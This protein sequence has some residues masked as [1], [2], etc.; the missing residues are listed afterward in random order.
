MVIKK[1]F[2]VLSLVFA[3]STAACATTAAAQPQSVGQGLMQMLPMFVIFIAVFYFLMIRPQNKKAQEKKQLM[4]SL[5]AG[6]E[7][8]TSGGIVAKIKQLS[9]GYVVLSLC[10]AEMTLQRN[11]IAAVLPNGTI[12]AIK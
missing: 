6:D 3:I 10:D 12:D 5:K 11:A 7:V 2:S 1:L 4:D 9:D 8:V